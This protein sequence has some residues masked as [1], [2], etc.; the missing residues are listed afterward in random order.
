MYFCDTHKL[1]VHFLPS[2]ILQDK[3]VVSFG[4]E[5]GILGSPPELSLTFFLMSNKSLRLHLGWSVGGCCGT[6]KGP[7]LLLPLSCKQCIVA[8]LPRVPK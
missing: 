5:L 4:Q 3:S 6:L 8:G 2:Q 7:D 1:H